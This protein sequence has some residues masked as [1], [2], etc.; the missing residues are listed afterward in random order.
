MNTTDV[1]TFLDGAANTP[2]RRLVARLALTDACIGNTFA[3]VAAVYRQAV[4]DARKGDKRAIEF[5]DITA[6]DW[7]ELSRQHSKSVPERQGYVFRAT[8][9][10]SVNQ[11]V[12]TPTGRYRGDT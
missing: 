5:L 3:L 4:K 1:Q 7:Q 11:L 10:Y 8:R 2:S 12:Q 6:P 9:S